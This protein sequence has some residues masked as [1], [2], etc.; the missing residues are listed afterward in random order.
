MRWVGLVAC[1]VSF[2][3]C[4]GHGGDDDDDL[5]VAGDGDGDTDGD[6]DADADMDADADAD[7]D[8]CHDLMSSQGTATGLEYCDTEGTRDVYRAE[9][10]AC[11]GG[12][13]EIFLCSEPCDCSDGTTCVR[14]PGGKYC[15]CVRGCETDADCGDGSAC[16]C[17]G[18]VPPGL[19]AADF[20]YSRCLPAS[21]LSD[22]DCPTGRC[23]LAINMCAR[24]SGFACRHE[25]DGCTSNA[26]CRDFLCTHYEDAWSCDYQGEHCN[27]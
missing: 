15:Y 10:L 23:A 4:G 14:S 1:A 22:A 3:S 11:V 19:A 26:D 2:F 21:C 6:A 8:V 12:I 17:E 24:P 7:A 13:P 16:L 20:S 5:I 27:E 9:A 25:G 18:S